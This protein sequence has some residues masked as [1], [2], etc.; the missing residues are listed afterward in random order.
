[1][2]KKV[3]NEF[4]KIIMNQTNYDENLAKQKLKEWD[5]NFVNVIKEYLNP[6]FNKKKEEPKLSTNQKVFSSI[7]KF[8]DT[9]SNNYERKKQYRE[10]INRQKKM[11]EEIEKE[12]KLEKEAYEKKIKENKLLEKE[13]EEKRVE[14]EKQDMINENKLDGIEIKETIHSINDVN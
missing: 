4:I 2:N 10:Y 12:S 13:K 5:N 11:Q 7:R 1:M 8:M 14:K 9:A 3:E 6:K